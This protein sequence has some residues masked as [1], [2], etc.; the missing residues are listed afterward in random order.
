MCT[1]EWVQARKNGLNYAGCEGGGLAHTE[2]LCN[3]NFTFELYIVGWEVT[4]VELRGP[5]DETLRI[6]KVKTELHDSTREDVDSICLQLKVVR[7]VGGI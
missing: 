6:Y 3:Q 7:Y 1:E 5:D 2:P 4:Y